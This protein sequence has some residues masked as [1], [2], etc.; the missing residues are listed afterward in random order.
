M[1]PPDNSGGGAR[2]HN[3]PR[4][5]AAN[6]AATKQL[7]R[8]QDRTSSDQRRAQRALTQLADHALARGDH[9]V[10]AIAR[11]LQDAA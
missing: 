10:A 5:T 1:S 7:V 6:A 11:W 2:H 4:P 9:E 3:R 8:V